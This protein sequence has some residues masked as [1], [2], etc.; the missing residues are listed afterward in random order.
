[1]AYATG[2]GYRP[3]QPVMGFGENAKKWVAEVFFVT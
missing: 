2:L 3:A 1:M